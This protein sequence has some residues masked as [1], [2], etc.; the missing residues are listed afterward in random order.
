MD[1]YTVV[2]TAKEYCLTLIEY[3]IFDSIIKTATDTA[4]TKLKKLNESETRI[5]KIY[6]AYYDV[7]LF[8]NFLLLDFDDYA[9]FFSREIFV[10]WGRIKLLLTSNRLIFV[11]RSNKVSFDGQIDTTFIKWLA[12]YLC[13]RII[14][15]P[16]FY[17]KYL[18]ALITKIIY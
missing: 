5:I 2:Y 9:L 16:L 13:L 12:L 1:S 8:W 6:Q 10:F 15:T 17:E 3:E 11:L 18:I 4:I 7:C 14:F